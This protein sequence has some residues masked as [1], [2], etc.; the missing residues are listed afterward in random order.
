MRL[1]APAGWQVTPASAPL[2]FT[3]ED[4]SLSARFE[5]TPPAGVKP[6]AYAVRAVA[7]SPAT[8]A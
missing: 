8:G 7:T 2:D 5:V 1:E 3:R 6:G 4:E